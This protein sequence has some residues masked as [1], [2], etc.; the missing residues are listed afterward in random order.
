MFVLCALAA[1]GLDLAARGRELSTCAL[2]IERADVTGRKALLENP[3]LRVTARH[4]VG[5]YRQ[6]SVGRAQQEIALRDI[7]L[8]R[9][10]QRLKERRVGLRIGARRA[11]TVAYTT[12]QIEFVLRGDTDLKTV[13][14]ITAR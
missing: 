1:Q 2:D 3:Q 5:E 13:I 6:F 10:Q 11:Q 8:D 4:G 12:Q 7:G 14:G 9:Q